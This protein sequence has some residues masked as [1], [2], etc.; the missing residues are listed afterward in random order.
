MAVTNGLSWGSVAYEKAEYVSGVTQ[1]P[2]LALDIRISQTANNDIAIDFDYA[3][4]AL[5]AMVI[6]EMLQTLEQ[7]LVEMSKVTNLQRVN[8]PNLF[9]QKNQQVFNIQEGTANSDTVSGVVVEDY[10]EK[11]NNHLYGN[12]NNKTALIC[13]DRAISYAELGK[14]IA[15]IIGQLTELNISK[16]AI[17]AICL[18]K[19]PE[20][21]AITLACSLTNIIWLPIDMDSPVERIQFMLSNCQTDL[22]ISDRQLDYDI[23]TINI[24]LILNNQD[25]PEKVDCQ[26]IFDGEPGYYLYT[27]GS[28]GTPKCVVMNHLATA[29]VVELTNN[30]WNLTGSDVLFAATPFHH[31]MS[32]YE[33]F[34][35]MSLGASLV[36]PDQDQTKSAMDWARLVEQHQVSVWSSVPAIVDMLLTCAEPRQIRSLKLVS[37][38]GDYVKPSLIEK[39]RQYLPEARLFSIGGPTETTIWSIWHEIGIEDTDIIPYGNALKNNRYYILNDNNQHCPNFVIGT[40]CMSGVNLANGYL[41]DGIINQTDYS[42]ITTQEGQ[43]V[44]VFKTSDRGYFRE[45]GKIIFSGRKEGYLKV[46]GVRIASAE[47]ELSL[48]KHPAVRDTIALTCVNPRYG[49]NELIAVYV[50]ENNQDVSTSDLRQFLK[51][52]LPNSHIPSRWLQLESF[53]LTR[54]R[55]V[56]RKQLKVLAEQYIYQNY[57]GQTVAQSASYDVSQSTGTLASK[58]LKGI[59]IKAFSSVLEQRQATNLSMQTDILSLGI[60]AKQLNQIAKQLSQD[61]EIDF[62]LYTLVKAT[63]LDDVAQAMLQKVGSHT[64]ST[65]S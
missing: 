26:P 20:H 1:T 60:R 65:G 31:D 23:K 11:I 51:S 36:I 43:Q 15:K 47:I 62:S 25:L 16:G 54:N 49:A 53:P 33:I 55:K 17:V 45:D 32:V 19:G 57:D 22:V 2:Q 63:T 48:T 13:G 61:T 34:G 37:Q 14:Q 52:K 56:D 10:L 41:N 9:S 29:N 8:A 12:K 46:R 21:V 42:V 7:Y 18:P 44:R 59:V 35:A 30:K 50:T 38:G 40:I 6:S 39:L 58:Q 3:E 24:H 27:S 28:T 5:P 64:E 4:Q